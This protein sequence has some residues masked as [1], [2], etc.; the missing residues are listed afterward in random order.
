[1]EQNNDNAKHVFGGALVARLE[2]VK[3]KH[4]Q[5][6]LEEVFQKMK[7]KG[8]T[9]PENIK[10]IK[11]QQK[12]PI[13]DF[14]SLLEIYSE[15]YG[16]DR[17]MVMSRSAPKRKGIV[18][19]FIR[20]AATPETILRKSGEYWPYFYDFGRLEGRLAAEKK[21]ILTGHDIFV[22]TIMCESLTNYFLGVL[23][24]VKVQNPSC[25][26]TSCVNSAAKVCQWTLTWQ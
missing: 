13:N 9:G 18:G 11:L 22:K 14:I 7:R 2:Y 3:T 19:W 4:G 15:L 21:G 5:L 25:K 16:K 23:E 6:G 8:Y 20:W 10:D 17:L 24:N 1:M 26:H 12:F